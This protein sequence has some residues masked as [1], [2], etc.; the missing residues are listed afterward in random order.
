MAEEPITTIGINLGTRYVGIAVIIGSELR[1]WRIRVIKGKEL[2]DKF[3]CLTGILARLIDSYAPSVVVL[4]KPHPMKTSP[5]LN[6]IQLEAKAFLEQNGVTVQE[7]TLNQLKMRLLPDQK[8]L[9]KIKLAE[10]ITSQYPILFEEWKREIGLK[11]P[12][13]MAMFEA[14]ALASLQA[15]D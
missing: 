11:R 2:I 6:R 5:V 13:R 14:V 4:K 15:A 3:Q 7:Y 10:F 1:D 9:N 12:Y 8:S